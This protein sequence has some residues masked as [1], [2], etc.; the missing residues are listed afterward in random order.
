MKGLGF[1]PEQKRRVWAMKGASGRWM[2][3]RLM[4][5]M[6]MMSIDVDGR[7]TDGRI[8]GSNCLWMTGRRMGGRQIDGPWKMMDCQSEQM[9]LRLGIGRWM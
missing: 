7:Q 4:W 9:D 6:G 8:W 1:N 3:D 2:E 5:M